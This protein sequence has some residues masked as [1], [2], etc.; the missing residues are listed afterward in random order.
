MKSFFAQKKLASI[1]FYEIVFFFDVRMNERKKRE[2]Q[3]AE[4]NSTVNNSN[5]HTI[6]FEYC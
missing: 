4:I 6:I 5:E 1:R 3:I 2:N